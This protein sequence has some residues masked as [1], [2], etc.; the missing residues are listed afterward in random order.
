MEEVK[1][2]HIER[3]PY[4][5]LFIDEPNKTYTREYEFNRNTLEIVGIQLTSRFFDRL[6]LRGT[7]RM[8]IG[9][10]T[11]F[12]EGLPSRL[13]M[14]NDG[15]VRPRFFPLSIPVPNDLALKFRF[16]DHDHP[17]APFGD[18]YDV[19]VSMITKERK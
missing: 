7:Q 13:F 6:S 10:D 16:R 2:E 17:Y 11:V 18:G 1:I 12:D 4:F 14:S 5:Q 9:G 3:Y 19:F 15:A 8:E